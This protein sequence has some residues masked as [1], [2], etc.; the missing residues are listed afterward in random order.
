[1]SKNDSP[2]PVSV[3]YALSVPAKISQEKSG[4]LMFSGGYEKMNNK[5]LDKCLRFLLQFL[6]YRHKTMQVCVFF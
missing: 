1:M 6:N 2:N 4:L 5:V 3:E